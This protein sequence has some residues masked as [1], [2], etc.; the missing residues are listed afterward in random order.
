MPTKYKKTKKPSYWSWKGQ[1]NRK[2]K[3][4][5]EKEGTRIRDPLIY[6]I[7]G[8]MKVINRKL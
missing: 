1:A 7:R 6:I 4:P 3:D 2:R 5:E 8:P